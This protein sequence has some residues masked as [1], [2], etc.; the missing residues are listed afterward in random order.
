[1]ATAKKTP[2]R[3]ATPAASAPAPAPSVAE[4]PA[5]AVAYVA[6]AAEAAAAPAAD[7]APANAA[8]VT[9]DVA[10]VYAALVPS[11]PAAVPAAPVAPAEADAAKDATRA[12]LVGSVPI[13]HDDRVYGVGHEITLTL[14]QATR[15]GG[16]VV[17]IPETPLE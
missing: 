17:S 1:M 10:S 13:R 7:N 4:A 2:T 5:P 3:P 12:Y 16:L 14:A 15:L 8:P 6:T 9:T 11:A